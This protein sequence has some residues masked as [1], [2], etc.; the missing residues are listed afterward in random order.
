MMTYLAILLLLA[1]AGLTT[2]LV[3][4]ELALRLLQAGNALSEAGSRILDR[5]KREAR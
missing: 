3:R 1:A 5:A 4:L 2:R